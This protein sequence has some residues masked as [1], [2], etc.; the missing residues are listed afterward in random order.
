MYFLIYS[1]YTTEF[2]NDSL[3][4]L[5]TQSRE[6]NKKLG[7]TGML[8]FLGLKF[9]Q[10][11]EGEEKA[12]KTLYNEI[13]LDARHKS[14]VLLNEGT[15]KEQMFAGWAMAFN[16]VYPED[17]TNVEGLE[18]LNSSS[19]LQVFKKLSLEI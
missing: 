10:L 6:K 12:V 19:V 3:K 16:S 9:V 18:R 13:C 11:L 8:L 15:T 1:S 17:F 14:V 4:I 7:I 2:N 5:L